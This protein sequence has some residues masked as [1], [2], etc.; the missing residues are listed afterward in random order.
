MTLVSS[1]LHAL[2]VVVVTAHPTGAIASKAPAPRALV[3]AQNPVRTP[4]PSEQ[5]LPL[6]VAA[7]ATALA[8]APRAR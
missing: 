6:A 2:G 4:E 3:F 8:A 5:V 7:S 1:S